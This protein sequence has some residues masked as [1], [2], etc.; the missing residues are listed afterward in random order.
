MNLLR[1]HWKTVF[2]AI[3]TIALLSFLTFALLEPE[4]H[5][6]RPSKEVARVQ[7]KSQPKVPKPTVTVEGILILVNDERAKVGVQPLKMN[8]ALMRSAQEKCDDMVA[9]HY[10][11]H[12]NPRTGKHG[13]EYAIS[14]VGGD[15]HLSE[16]LIMRT[17]TDRG[18]VNGWLYSPPHKE[19]MLN[20]KY[21]ATGIALCQ[22]PTTG[23]PGYYAVQHF[24]QL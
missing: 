16:N 17:D 18:T 10:Y 22:D 19:A 21:T 6:V 15:V 8:D 1:L 2:T 4:N 9:E 5:Q 20:Q 13:Y 7:Q 11:G 12:V 23:D 14:A 24:A 3:A